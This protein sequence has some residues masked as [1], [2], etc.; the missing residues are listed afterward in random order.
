M[1]QA[2]TRLEVADNSGAQIVGCIRVLGGSTRRKRTYR[3]RTAAVGQIIICSVKKASPGGEVKKGDIV[4]CVI[5]RT[6]HPIR[7]SDGSYV[8]FDKNAVVIVDADGNPRGTRIFGAVARELR[9]L[10]FMKI[11]SLANE[12][13]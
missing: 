1:I 2:E 8:R 12:V 4:R 9:E 6:A 11:V 5:V 3:R 13:V 7:R 10:S